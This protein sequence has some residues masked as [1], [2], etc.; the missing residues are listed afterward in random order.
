MD[1]EH[2]HG[3]QLVE[4]G[5]GREAAGERFEA[6]TQRDV[7][8]VGDERDEDVGLDALFEVMVDR[9]QAEVILEVLEGGLDLDQLN[10][11]LPQAGW[12]LPPQPIRR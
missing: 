11:E 9:A 4:H 2:L 3:R 12:V 7:K 10:V 5:A 1:V 6:G 8:A